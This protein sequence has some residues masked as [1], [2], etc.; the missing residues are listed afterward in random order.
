MFWLSWAG[1]SIPIRATLSAVIFEKAMRRKNV[2]TAPTTEKAIATPESVG[3]PGTSEPATSDTEN[4]RDNKAKEDEEEDDSNATKSRQ[5]IINL[6]GVDAK[7]VADFFAFQYLFPSSASKLIISIWFLIAL[8]GWIPLGAGLLTWLL[9]MPFNVH[10]SKVYTNAQ[11]R[12]MKIRDQKLAVV[13]ESLQGMR[14]IK[15]S[16]LESQW[17]KRILDMREKEL[18]AVWDVF[19]GDTILFACW[20]TSPI[21][22]AAAS[23]AVYALIH[24]EL[25]PSV[26]FGKFT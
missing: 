18:G 25:T 9:I 26:A 13:N 19:R 24:K 23:L 5:G 2:K 11:E 4:S 7:R 3:P 14:Q 6:V 17:E 21:A 1:L 15:F 22:L 20:V 8:L 16:A 10:F 12:L